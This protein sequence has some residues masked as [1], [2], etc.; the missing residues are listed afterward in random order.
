MINSTIFPI[1]QKA[2]RTIY[3]MNG[4]KRAEH[5]E[6]LVESIQKTTMGLQHMLA[7]INKNSEKLDEIE[8]HPAKLWGTVITAVLSAI[9]SGFAE[10][11]VSSAAQS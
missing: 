10:F 9:G 4:D 5:I 11:F 8:K 6:K 3:D 7:D 1:I 2:V